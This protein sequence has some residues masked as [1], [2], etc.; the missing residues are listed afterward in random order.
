MHMYYIGWVGCQ[1]CQYRE[2]ICV[3]AGSPLATG[4][5]VEISCPND[6]SRHRFSLAHMQP[7]AECPPDLQPRLPG[8][9]QPTQIQTLTPPV[10]WVPHGWIG[11]IPIWLS[12]ILGA[13]AV[14]AVMLY[15]GGVPV[16][17]IGF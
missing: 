5:F 16:R 9:P 4:A 8:R 12:V 17:W 1:H 15:Y 14:A 10:G 7:A 11:L 13:V 3:E 2:R 6:G